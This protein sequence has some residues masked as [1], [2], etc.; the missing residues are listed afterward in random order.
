V[1]FTAVTPYPGTKLHRSL[2]KEI[3]YEDLWGYKPMGVCRNLSDDELER[4]IKRAFRRFYLRPGRLVRELGSPGTLLRRARRYLG[5][6][7]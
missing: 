1:Q 2:E 7:R 3:R 4:E 6:Y 5:L